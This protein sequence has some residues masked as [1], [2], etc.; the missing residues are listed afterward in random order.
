[1]VRSH[2]EPKGP[3]SRYA[4]C[5]VRGNQDQHEILGAEH[6]IALRFSIATVAADPIVAKTRALSFQIHGAAPPPWQHPSAQA[7]AA[8]VL[9]PTTLS[10]YCPNIRIGRNW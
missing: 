5:P 7:P 2:M 8:I 3:C 6:R 9:Q 10:S 4:A 1:M